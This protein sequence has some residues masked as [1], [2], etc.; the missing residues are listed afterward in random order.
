MARYIFPDKVASPLAKQFG[1]RL[2]E[3]RL[4]LAMSQCELGERSG[5]AVSLIIHIE[6][7]EANPTLSMM[8]NLSA[9]V[10][11]YIMEL[12]SAET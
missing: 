8:G 5:V 7:G 1:D 4:A 6:R 12:F 3:R 9:A 2:R 10:D 11:C